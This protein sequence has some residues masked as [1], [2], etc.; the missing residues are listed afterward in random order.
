MDARRGRDPAQFHDLQFEDFQRD[1][2]AAIADIYD[3]FSLP[4]AAAAE[5]AMAGF[6]REN[7][8][9]KYGEHRVALSDW[10]LEAGEIRE[11]FRAYTDRFQIPSEG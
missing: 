6:R 1:P 9:G 10:G 7:P 11:R 8:R 2:L 4:M 3:H 5:S